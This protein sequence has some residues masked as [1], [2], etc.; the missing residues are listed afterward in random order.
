[1]PWNRTDPEKE[2]MA[3]VVE[4]Q[5]GMRSM[6]ALCRAYGVS[7][8]TGYRWVGRVAAEGP[9]GCR[10]RSRAP[11]QHP[12]ALPERIRRVMVETRLAHPTWGPRKIL[13]FWEQQE[14]GDNWPAAS[15]IGTILAQEGLVHPRRRRHASPPYGQPFQACRGPNDVWC[16]DFKGWFRTGDGVRCDPLTITDAYSRMLLRCAGLLVP[17]YAAV[18]PV[19][20]ATFHEYGLPLAIRTD[21]GPPFA[22]LAVGGLSQLSVWWLKL[23]IQPERIEPGHPEQNGRHERMHRTLKAETISPPAADRLAQQ[24]CFDAFQGE[25][26]H[27]RPHEALG[28]RPPAVLYVP[29]PRPYP[30]PLLEFTYP[31]ADLLRRVRSSGDIKW[32]QQSIFLSEVLGGEAVGLY[33]RLEGTWE[34]RFGPVVLGS[35]QEQDPAPRLRRPKPPGLA[36]D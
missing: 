2:R 13:A 11:K 5:R 14:P 15:T 35:F 19:F 8:K 34:V 23:G 21:N 20:E 18:R 4:Y 28:Q 17:T 27:I 9:A 12:H 31:D 3:F 26:N 16:A 6:T 32:H 30:V 10:D 29:S 7:R 22:S 25:Y 33:H 36:R 24:A 1:M